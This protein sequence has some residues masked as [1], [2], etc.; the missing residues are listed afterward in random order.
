MPRTYIKVRCLIA[1]ALSLLVSGCAGIASH[2]ALTPP[3]GGRAPD[4]TGRAMTTATV[5]R[6]EGKRLAT[7]LER[8]R[9]ITSRARSTRGIIMGPD[10]PTNPP[11]GHQTSGDFRCTGGC[12]GGQWTNMGN[13]TLFNVGVTAPTPGAYVITGYTVDSHG[14][15]TPIPSYTVNVSSDQAGPTEEVNASSFIPSNVDMENGIYITVTGPNGNDDWTS[16]ACDTGTG[17]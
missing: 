3:P 2:N 17:G 14:I 1:L 16:N 5:G 15:E 7:I 6:A 13:G 11:A 9:E 12:T 8:R 4:T 10:G